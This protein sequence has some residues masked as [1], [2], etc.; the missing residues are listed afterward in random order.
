MK[1]LSLLQPWASLIAQGD[2]RI[3]TRSWSTSYRGQI[4][5]HASARPRGAKWQGFMDV[6]ETGADYGR[7]ARFFHEAIPDP[8]TL[9]FGAIIAVVDLAQI[10]T[11][12]PGKLRLFPSW[13]G[14]LSDKERAFGD[15]TP[16]RYAWCLENIRPLPEPVPCRGALCLWDAPADVKA[17]VMELLE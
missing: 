12:T 4:A 10:L 17:R 9:P 5:I 6:C 7:T 15:Y 2:K 1:A 8:E 14:S 11:T 13:P 3:E 16:G